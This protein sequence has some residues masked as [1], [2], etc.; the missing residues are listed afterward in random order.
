[1]R[2]TKRDSFSDK[3][4][5]AV[6]KEYKGVCFDCG[7][8][9]KGYWHDGGTPFRPKKTFTIEG[10]NIHHIIPFQ[11]GGKHKMDNWVLLCIECH[12]ERH[13]QIEKNRSI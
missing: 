12:K 9:L 10:A 11:Y 8:P 13:R 6:Y 1:M 3:Q 4:K 7:K 5:V 2:I